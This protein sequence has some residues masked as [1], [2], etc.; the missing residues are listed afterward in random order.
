MFRYY[1]VVIVFIF[2]KILFWTFFFYLRSRRL[3]LLQRRGVLIIDRSGHLTTSNHTDLATIIEYEDQQRQHFHNLS[4]PQMADSPPPYSEVVQTPPPLYIN[5]MID[6]QNPSSLTD[7]CKPPTYEQVVQQQQHT[8]APH[9]D[10][11]QQ[12]QQQLQDQSQ[13]PQQQ[14]PQQQ[15]PQQENGMNPEREYPLL[16]SSPHQHL[17]PPPPYSCNE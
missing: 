6:P 9:Q 11:Q 15:Q 10:Q 14:Q 2:L 5:P 17:P 12:Q 8:T 4:H 13:Q 3:R 1:Y 16:N 7:T